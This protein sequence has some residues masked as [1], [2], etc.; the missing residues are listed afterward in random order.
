MLVSEQYSV[1]ITL[2]KDQTLLLCSVL[3]C[4]SLFARC[5]V[6]AWAKAGSRGWLR[7]IGVGIRGPSGG[8]RW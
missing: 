4:P 7:E 5:T 3:H 2:D 8:T 1:R 6:L